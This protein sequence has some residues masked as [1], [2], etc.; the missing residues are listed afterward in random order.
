MA[1]KT[2]EP[3]PPVTATAELT[4]TQLAALV[5]Q[6]AA[7]AKTTKTAE[8]REKELKKQLVDVAFPQWLTLNL[9][10]DAE[11]Q[12]MSMDAVGRS[13]IAQVTF[14]NKYAP[15]SDEQ[16]EQIKELVSPAQA[17]VITENRCVL[18]V[19]CSMIADDQDELEEF[20]DE[21]NEL[22]YI[23]GLPK[24][25]QAATT[26]N[27]TEEFHNTRHQKFIPAVNKRLNKISPVRTQ[28][29]V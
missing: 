15:L 25:E 8:A 11:D 9:Q 24:I 14:I 2:L 28:V 18:P 27:F 13:N 17:G 22:L 29:T 21:L 20:L 19:D 6:I 16:L 4:G 12:C 7:A 10:E 23:Y 1:T 5:D 26:T 3:N